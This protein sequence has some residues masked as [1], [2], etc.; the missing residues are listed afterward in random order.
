MQRSEIKMK[1]ESLRQQSVNDLPR[2]EEMFRKAR[3]KV[4]L[5]TREVE[6]EA[7]TGQRLAQAVHFLGSNTKREPI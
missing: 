3:N 7:K 2:L 5:I 4:D 1:I 6:N